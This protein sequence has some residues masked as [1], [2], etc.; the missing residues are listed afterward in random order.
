M[1]EPETTPVEETQTIPAQTI[2]AEP[3]GWHPV[4]ISHLVMGVAFAGLF[5]VWALISS[6]TVELVDAHWLLPL[7]WLVAGVVGLVATVLRNARRR[8]GKMSG[9]I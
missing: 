2:A 3:R 9:W 5:T 4:N 6:D 8:D 7:P 1:S